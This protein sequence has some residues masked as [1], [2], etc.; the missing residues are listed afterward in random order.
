ML[1]IRRSVGVLVAVALVAATLILGGQVPA[2]ADPWGNVDCE[3]E[4]DHPVCDVEAGSSGGVMVAGPRGEVVCHLDGEVVPC[5]TDEGW[6]GSDG[7][8]YLRLEEVAPPTGVTDPGA[9][10]RVRCPGDPPNWQ[11]ALVWLSDAEAPG[12]AEL[13]R[14][15]ASRLL[16]PRPEVVV[17]PPAPAPQLVMLPTWL[18]VEE[19]WWSVSRSASASVPGV[20]VT[21]TATP[22]R[23]VWS[24]GDGTTVTCEGSGTPYTSEVGSPASASPDCGHIYRRASSAQPGGLFEVSATVTW[25]V[26]WSGGGASG[27]AGPLFSTAT[28]P[29]TVVEV[30][31][32]NTGGGR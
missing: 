12:P 5:V 19:T 22:I 25:Q 17:N 27:V 26:S 32:V 29:V 28:V 21:A 9:A 30:R 23:V 4:P 18:W 10:Y 20:T 24:M 2:Y 31:S 15:A 7:C 6:L 13:G 1:A 3:Q 11:R 8:R 14:I 16:L